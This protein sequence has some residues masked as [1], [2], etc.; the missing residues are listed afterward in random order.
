MLTSVLSS[1]PSPQSHT[2]P[3]KRTRCASARKM[4]AGLRCDVLCVVCPCCVCLSCP[5]STR[6]LGS[7][8]HTVKCS[9][10]LCRES[11]RS[12][13]FLVSIKCQ[14]ALFTFVLIFIVYGNLV[15]AVY[16]YILFCIRPCPRTFQRTTHATLMTSGWA[17]AGKYT[18]RHCVGAP[19]TQFD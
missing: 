19:A 18:L 15:D 12:A 2:L 3:S 10:I 9:F 7:S 8:N 5:Y 6:D 13:C 16:M 14:R 4:I 1:Q 17:R 11:D